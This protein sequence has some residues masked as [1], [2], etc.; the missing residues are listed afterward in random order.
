MQVVNATG[1][2]CL[3]KRASYKFELRLVTDR[4]INMVVIIITRVSVEGMER[5]DRGVL[6][7]KRGEPQP[8]YQ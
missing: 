7:V 3:H 4:I 2:H 1:E 6:G 5:R 8:N